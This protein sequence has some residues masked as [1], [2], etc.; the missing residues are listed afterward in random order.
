MFRGNMLK[1]LEH[2]PPYPPIW[3]LIPAIILAQSISMR[4][5]VKCITAPSVDWRG[6]TYALEGGGR[7][8]LMEY[9]PYSGAE[10]WKEASRSVV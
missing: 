2:V 10:R 9:R 8:R 3:K 7:V 6:V 1:R 5:L 4:H